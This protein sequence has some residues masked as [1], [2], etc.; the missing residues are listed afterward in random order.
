MALTAREVDAR[1]ATVLKARIAGRLALAET[2]DLT[3]GAC[4]AASAAV[5]EIAACVGTDAVA[6]DLLVAGAVRDSGIVGCLAVGGRVRAV[7]QGRS[8]IRRR[9]DGCV[10]VVAP[11]CLREQHRCR[12]DRCRFRYIFLSAW[13]SSSSI[14]QY[15]SNCLPPKRGLEPIGSSG[16][17]GA[18]SRL[19]FFESGGLSEDLLRVVPRES[20]AVSF[21]II[22]RGGH[23]ARM[24]RARE[25]SHPLS[26]DNFMKWAVRIASEKSIEK[27][28]RTCSVAAGLRSHRLCEEGV[29]RGEL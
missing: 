28:D 22:A 18:D 16:L 9:R 8:R 29:L 25:E 24:V 19:G 13:V 12:R 15:G 27:S 5:L 26:N 7:W 1:T 20:G 11:A 3:S 17:P 23:G 10:V 2:A 6:R 21:R 14:P 4:R